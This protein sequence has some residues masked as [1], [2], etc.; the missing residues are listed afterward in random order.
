MSQGSLS[1]RKATPSVGAEVQAA[2]QR[3]APLILVVDDV[4]MFR[5]LETLFLERHGRVVCARS[6]EE[7]I[8]KMRAQ[9]ADVA[10][11][12]LHLPDTSGE[13]LCAE[14]RRMNPLLPVVVVSNGASEEHRRAVAAGATDVISKPLSRRE[15]V[16][17]VT[18]MLVPG[19]PRGLP[20]VPIHSLAR[21]RCGDRLI[22]GRLH[23]ISRGGAFLGTD[24]CPA[25]GTEFQLDF[26]VGEPAEPM[27]ASATAVWRQLR[28]TETTPQGIGLR[29][30]D[31]DAASARRL[32]A[33]VHEHYTPSVLDV[34]Q[35]GSE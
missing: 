35:G 17:A 26:E 4:P 1:L 25:E 22:E 10:V 3:R 28:S 16:A 31:L 27:S 32:E 34:W 9:P 19:G 20:R 2:R 15:L 30:L 6:G 11:I 13:L 12:D 21:A 14:L 29:F 33:Y 18:R 8:A 7:A 24:W 23:N 5:E